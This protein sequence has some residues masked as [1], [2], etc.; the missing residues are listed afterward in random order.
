MANALAGL[1]G[2]NVTYDDV[3]AFLGAKGANA[4]CPIC[5]SSQWTVTDPASALQIPSNG[6]TG[7]TPVVVIT[8]NNCGYV[9]MHSLITIQAWKSVVG[10]V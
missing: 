3:V 9:R 6:I 8:C 5:T 2:S 10:R 1:F 4:V 7:A